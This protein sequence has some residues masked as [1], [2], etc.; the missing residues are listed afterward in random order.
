MTPTTLS[1]R[2][3]ILA[4][5]SRFCGPRLVSTWVWA[6]HYAWGMGAWGEG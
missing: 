5:S 1:R 2:I 6:G 4:L 3:R